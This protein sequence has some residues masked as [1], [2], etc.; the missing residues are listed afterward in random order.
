MMDYKKIRELGNSGDLTIEVSL[1]RLE[2]VYGEIDELK[3]NLEHYNIIAEDQMI[4]RTLDG[5]YTGKKEVIHEL[6]EY[7]RRTIIEPRDKIDS[8]CSGWFP[9]VLKK[10][11]IKIFDDALEA[12]RKQREENLE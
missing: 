6:V 11:I 9:F 8:A 7:A 5:E 12:D 1:D 3:G 10:R 2:K 4:L